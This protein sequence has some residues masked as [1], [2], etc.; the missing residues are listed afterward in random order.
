MRKEVEAGSSRVCQHCQRAEARKKA[1]EKVK[2][3]M[4]EIKA[5]TTRISAHNESLKASIQ[6]FSTQITLKQATHSQFQLNSIACIR[7]LYEALDQAKASREELALL[8]SDLHLSIA[9]KSANL[10]SVHAKITTLNGQ[11]K[12][13]YDS[14]EEERKMVQFLERELRERHKKLRF[15]VPKEPCPHLRQVS[16][17]EDPRDPLGSLACNLRCLLM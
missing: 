10:A 16:P 3:E 13:M 12:E 1:K 4:M 7:P 6:A 15:S 2:A 5:E 17:R 14:T 11:M 9:S 8:L